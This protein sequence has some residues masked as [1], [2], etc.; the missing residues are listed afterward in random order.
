MHEGGM[1]DPITLGL[2]QP[3][4]PI[5]KSGEAA[6]QQHLNAIP[7]GKRGALIL[8]YERS[9]TLLPRLQI[10]TAA[11]INGNWAVGA[12][13]TLQQKAKPTTRFYSLFT[14]V[15]VLLVAPLSGQTAHKDADGFHTVPLAQMAT[16]THTH[17]CT[18]GPVVYMRKQADGDEH[19]TIDDGTSMVVVEIIPAIP[20][21][22]PK[23]GQRIK[24]CGITRI[25][26]GHR[27]P[28]YPGG[29]P[30]LHPLLSWEPLAP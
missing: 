28:R 1:S 24:A 26:R 10:G 18:S 20:L 3:D 2:N 9:S 7:D 15:L 14:W 30:E 4:R 21:P 25:D 6:L 12:D 16:T 8:G 27:T 29:W 13:V 11:R 23:K 17:A 5:L 22:A 19:I